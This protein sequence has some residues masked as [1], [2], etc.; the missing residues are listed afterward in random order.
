MNNTFYRSNVDSFL[1]ERVEPIRSE[2]LDSDPK[3]SSEQVFAW[4]CTINILKNQLSK[5]EGME[6]ALEYTLPRMNSRIDAVL[7]YRGIVFVLEFKCGE[8]QYKEKTYNQVIDYAYDLHFCHEQSQ[9][10]LIVPIE[11]ATE[12]P[13]IENE[14]VEEDRVIFPLH[15]NKS[16]LSKYI[17]LIV[18]KYPDEKPIDA[19]VWLDSAF[20]PTP[21]I[22][23][24]ARYLYYHHSVDDIKKHDSTNLTETIDV[25]ND[26]IK[27]TKQNGTKSICFITGVPGAG[28]TLVGLTV[29]I[30]NSNEKTG[31][32]AAFLSGNGPLVN[33]LTEALARDIQAREH[34]DR[35]KSY[36]AAKSFIHNIFKFRMDGIQDEN[37][38]SPEQVVIFDEAQRAWTQDKLKKFLENPRRQSKRVFNYQ[39]SEPESLIQQM[40]RRKD[41]AVIICLVGGGQEIYQ[42]EAGLSEWFKAL[43]KFKDWRVYVTPQLNDQVYL[44]G[45]DWNEMISGLDV[46][47]EPDLHLT[48]SMRTLRTDALNRFVESLLSLELEDAAKYYSQLG[49][50]FPIVITRD[51]EK[52]K[53]WIETIATGGD[54]YGKLVSSSTKKLFDQINGVHSS[55]W[56]Q[57]DA[58]S[59]FLEGK[60]NPKSSYN[61]ELCASEFDVQGLELDYVLLEWGPDFRIEFNSWKYYKRWYKGWKDLGSV[62]YV[63]GQPQLSLEQVYILNTYRVLMTRARKGMVIYIPEGTVSNSDML[64]KYYEGVYRLFK[65]LNVKEQ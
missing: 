15:C 34:K 7:L 50:R 4:E 45:A 44:R 5:Y 21:T 10:R 47:E 63:N 30:D 60:S 9:G 12:A 28:K 22:I 49:R 3:A 29:A 41:C 32:H 57:F 16:N 20:K 36:T 25:V 27:K 13:V 23:E 62:V 14:I 2:L 11:V 64:P 58:P 35:S 52:A 31:E 54:R 24:A 56:E 1:D 26:I 51:L 46:I 59:W 48:V 42:G 6:I 40:N 37:H 39:L 18:E 55:S 53:M 61:L 33:T 17:D 43:K 38:V 8:R 19:K 65:S